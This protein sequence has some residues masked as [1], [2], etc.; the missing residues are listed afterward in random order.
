MTEDFSSGGV[1]VVTLV[2]LHIIL[3]IFRHLLI[4]HYLNDIIA[5]LCELVNQ[6]KGLVRKIN[7]SNELISV[8]GLPNILPYNIR[9]STM[10]SNK[11]LCNSLGQD[12]GFGNRR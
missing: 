3:D 8:S 10:V 11:T 1:C 9:I 7:R 4:A 12:I 6:T 5:L 2:E